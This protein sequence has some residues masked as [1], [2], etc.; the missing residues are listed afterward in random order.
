MFEQSSALVYPAAQVII[1]IIPIVGIVMGSVVIFFY[2]LWHHREVV[3]QIQAGQYRKPVFDLYLFS[4]LA[5]FLLTG[6]GLV[7]SLLFLLIEGLSYTLLGGLIPFSLGI[8]LLAF[9]FFTRSDRKRI[10]SSI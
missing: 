3:R 7:L 1:A 5:G 4:I 10:D 6:T 8:S 2:L 9:F